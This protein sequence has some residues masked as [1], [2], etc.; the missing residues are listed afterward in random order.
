ML[1]QML[2]RTSLGSAAA[3][4]V[5]TCAGPAAAQSADWRLPPNEEKL[6]TLTEARRRFDC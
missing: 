3:F 4:A 6:L 5:A 1:T 2:K